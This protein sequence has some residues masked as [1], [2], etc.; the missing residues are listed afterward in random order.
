MEDGLIP[1][2]LG[3][4]SGAFLALVFDPP[5][6]RMGFARRTAAA[7]V[8]G[9]IFGHIVLTFLEWPETYENV[10]AAFCTSAF[11]SW[12]AMGRIKRFIENYKKEA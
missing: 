11:V 6:S 4:A 3:V 12:A 7:L 10:V 2:L 8:A 9:Y 5:R 1:K